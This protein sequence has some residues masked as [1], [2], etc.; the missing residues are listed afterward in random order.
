MSRWSKFA[1]WL[2][3]IFSL[4]LLLAVWQVVGGL[5]SPVI[6]STPTRVAGALV[7]MLASGELLQAT[8]LTLLPLAL[9]L[10]LSLVVGVAM[11]L[12]L[13]LSR[14]SASLLNIYIFIFWATPTI[15]LLPLLVVWM[16]IGLAATVTFVFLNAVFPIILN[17]QT[18]VREVDRGLIEVVESLGARRWETIRTVV[19]PSVIPYVFAGIRIAIG[20]SMVA[21]IAAQLL[22][23]ATGIGYMLQFYGE[24]L[25]L[26]KYFAP[27]I[28]TAVL[29]LALTKGNDLLERH[30]VRWKPSAF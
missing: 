17:T 28:I 15:A 13:G 4:S 24:T 27:L 16:G 6:L 21:V 22:I 8:L 19:I 3:P 25:Q 1:D 23:T 5:V 10:G 18:G 14:V 26:A 7:E 29:A 11:G 20:R 30:L 2:L 12:L 9:G